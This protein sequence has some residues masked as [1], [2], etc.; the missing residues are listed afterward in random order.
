M[1]DGTAYDFVVCTDKTVGFVAR[2]FSVNRNKAY[3]VDDYLRSLK[4]EDVDLRFVAAR[5]E[6]V[7]VVLEIVEFLQSPALD[8]QE[9]T[10]IRSL[11]KKAAR[12][13]MT[14]VSEHESPILGEGASIGN[15]IKAVSDVLATAESQYSNIVEHMGENAARLYIDSLRAAVRSLEV[16]KTIQSI[17]S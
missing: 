17:K 9:R 3:V 4:V 14:Y 1:I 16:L 6:R 5:F 11:L 13:Y 15:Q 2:A 8:A 10:R 12:K 7:S